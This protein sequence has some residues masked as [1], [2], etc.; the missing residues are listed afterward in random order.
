MME[1]DPRIELVTKS[2]KLAKD[3]EDKMN[4]MA[5][6]PQ[7]LADPETPKLSRIYIKR[8]MLKMNGQDRDEILEEV[9]PYYEELCAKERATLINNNE[10]PP[11]IDNLNE[12][13]MTYLMIYN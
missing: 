3:K 7:L 5:F 8:K 6:A 13:H 11:K 4:F 9:P 12:D 10:L 2:E 1:K